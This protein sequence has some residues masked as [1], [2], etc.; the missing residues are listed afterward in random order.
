MERTCV[1]RPPG[2]VKGGQTTHHHV[3]LGRMQCWF[4]HGQVVCILLISACLCSG[5]IQLGANS[6]NQRLVTPEFGW[7]F[8]KLSYFVCRGRKLRKAEVCYDC[9]L[10][11]N[12]PNFVRL[13][14]TPAFPVILGGPGAGQKFWGFPPPAYEPENPAEPPLWA[15]ISGVARRKSSPGFHPPLD[16]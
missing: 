2:P 6:S 8:S 1:G 12:V 5:T 10:S 13:G 15:E 9:F 14:S 4:L 7:S 16:F 3:V 11:A